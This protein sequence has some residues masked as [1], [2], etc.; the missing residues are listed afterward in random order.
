[1]PVGETMVQER[2]GRETRKQ[3]GFIEH[4][5]EIRLIS[6]QLNPTKGHIIYVHTLDKEKLELSWE[7]SPSMFI[8]S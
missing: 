4:R 3:V 6:G 1:M 7:T 5:T 8:S 2:A